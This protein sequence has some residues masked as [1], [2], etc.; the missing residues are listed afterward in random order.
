MDNNTSEEFA[1]VTTGATEEIEKKSLLSCV[2][3]SGMLEKVMLIA[4]FTFVLGLGIQAVAGAADK[5][6]KEEK[7][8]IESIKADVTFGG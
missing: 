1:L 3:G 4:L 5:K 8:G 6:L 2:R 7:T